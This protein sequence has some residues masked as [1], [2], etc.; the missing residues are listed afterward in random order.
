MN[1][2]SL[3]KNFLLAICFFIIT[4]CERN[5]CI[6]ATDWGQPV[7]TVN[8]NPPNLVNIGSEQTAPW[9]DSGYKT[10]GDQVTAIIQGLP[11]QIYNCQTQTSDPNFIDKLLE[12]NWTPFLGNLDRQSRNRILAQRLG[13]CN[14][15]DS[16]CLDPNNSSGSLGITNPPC[17]LTKGRGLY[18]AFV[19]G[20][21]A[22]EQTIKKTVHL[23]GD[24][25][26]INPSGE[27]Q[28]IG[29]FNN[30]CK[31]GGKKVS[32][33]PECLNKQCGI[34][35]KILDKYYS[36]NH[37]SVSLNLTSGVSKISN[38]FITKTVAWIQIRLCS[39]SET[40]F[41]GIVKKSDYRQ[42][43]RILLILYVVIYAISFLLGFVE[44]KQSDLVIRIIKIGIIIQLI[45]TE[46]SWEF[47]NKNFFQFFKD[48][49]GILTGIIFGEGN[50]AGVS[51]SVDD[52]SWFPQKS[53]IS[54]SCRNVN[55]AGFR[56]LEDSINILF[57]EQLAAKA[58]GAVTSNLLNIIFFV[59][60]YI[61]IALIIFAIIR[62]VITYV[63]AFIGMS[64]L[65]VLAPIFIPFL[66]FQRTRSFFESWVRELI[67]SFIQP[68]V[69]LTFAFFMVQLLLNQI[70]YLFGYGV[71]TGE[72]FWNIISWKVNDVPTSA[73]ASQLIY[74]PS[75]WWKDSSSF[76]SAYQCQQVRNIFLPYLNP[77][78]P[79]DSERI[80]AISTG[81]IINLIDYAILCLS[82]WFLYEFNSMVPGIAKKL[83][84]TGMM[85]VD[86]AS[87]ASEA[88]KSGYDYSMQGLKM[89]GGLT[90]KT[91]Q[92]GADVVARKALSGRNYKRLQSGI[93]KAGVGLSL[94]KAGVKKVT[95]LP[96]KAL[97]VISN[98][99]DI[100]SDKII[101][102][103]NDALGRYEPNNSQKT[104]PSDPASFDSVRDKVGSAI[105]STLGTV[106]FIEKKINEKTLGLYKVDQSLAGQSK[107]R[108]LKA[109][110]RKLEQAYKDGKA[111]NA[112]ARAPAAPGAVPPPPAP[113]APG[114]PAAPPAPGA[115]APVDSAVGAGPAVPR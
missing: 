67:G 73:D 45:T 38:G 111:A 48:G 15:R 75:A 108:D 43:I 42:Y 66:L 47:F 104:P 32:P 37:G 30:G 27:L 114:A 65:I 7:V 8:S 83:S 71:C 10:N 25:Q 81:D 56:A 50:A 23:G 95:S 100:I 60:L 3:L 82:G 40:I 78:E 57:S 107:I 9:L 77:N 63:L 22:N 101:D 69:V 5:K 20:A 113:G 13:E 26:I 35:F 96:S 12:K 93:N 19:D 49:V 76:C 109:E 90:W 62:G 11:K 99:T 80:R 46:S 51:M 1:Y 28:T 18:M 87:S 74:V 85:G 2:S 115:G 44:V 64:I 68:I 70:Y 105:D 59:L 6:D 97:F 41:K 52:L 89:V 21:V 16:V 72:W 39:V 54:A 103:K 36:D 86:Y 53:Q 14:I 33:P 61:I 110:V 92:K 34:H 84:G 91:A 112:A 55:L 102:I 79:L 58:W 4:S 31:T 106:G 94:V 98:P 29:F 88:F 24:Q 17:I